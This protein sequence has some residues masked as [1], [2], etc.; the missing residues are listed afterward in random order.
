MFAQQQCITSLSCLPVLPTPKPDHT[1]HSLTGLIS[2]V[3]ILMHFR[4]VWIAPLLICIFC[5]ALLYLFIL[6][7]LNTFC[8][9]GNDGL[10][11]LIQNM[12]TD[13]SN[14]IQMGKKTDAMQQCKPISDFTFS[15]SMQRA[16]IRNKHIQAACKVLYLKVKKK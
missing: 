4:V 16:L 9:I 7:F 13:G 12:S 5:S 10:S 1:S 6:Y 15:R 11:S 14:C 8:V 3:G 2:W